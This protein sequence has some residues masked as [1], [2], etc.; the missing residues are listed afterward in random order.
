MSVM[1]R[2]LNFFALKILLIRRRQIIYIL[3][4]LQ[5]CCI[6]LLLLLKN[7]VKIIDVTVLNGQVHRLLIQTLRL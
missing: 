4:P 6:I 7:I 5:H 1:V 3:I 2:P